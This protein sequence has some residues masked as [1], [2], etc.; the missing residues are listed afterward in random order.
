MSLDMTI[1]SRGAAQADEADFDVASPPVPRV[2]LQKLAV[3]A[4][5]FCGVMLSSALGV[6]LFLR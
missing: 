3:G 2:W 4:A 5:A 1:A 6:L